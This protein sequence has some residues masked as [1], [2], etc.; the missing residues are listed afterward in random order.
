LAR[1]TELFSRRLQI[2][3]RLTRQ[4]AEAVQEAIQP[5]GVAVMMEAT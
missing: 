3:E 2:Q 1:I 5:T 4:V